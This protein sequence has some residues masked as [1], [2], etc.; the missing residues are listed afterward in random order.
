MI[1]T[2]T[3]EQMLTRGCSVIPVRPDKRP[4]IPTWK[5][6]QRTRPSVAQVRA[7][8]RK[9]KAKCWAVIA[10]SVS[11]LFVLDFDGETGNRTL[12]SLGLDPHVRTPSS[13]W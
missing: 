2:P 3:P 12:Q 8:R 7:W 10:G 13:P 9:L 4:A 11:E 5:E 6:Y 1:P